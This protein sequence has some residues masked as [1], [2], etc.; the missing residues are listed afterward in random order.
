[1]TT[2][3]CFVVGDLVCDFGVLPAA[4]SG[5]ARMG[6]GSPWTSYAPMVFS[7]AAA[8]GSYA[9]VGLLGWP[10]PVL[11][12]LAAAWISALAAAFVLTRR[13]AAGA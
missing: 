1:M 11:A 3:A 2:A 10:A 8:L 12:L 5:I 6:A 7:P 4:Y 9:R 13:A